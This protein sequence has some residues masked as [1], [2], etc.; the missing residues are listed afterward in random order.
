M[1]NKIDCPCCG[2]I[3]QLITEYNDV[4]VGSVNKKVWI[5]FT[6]YQCDYC[7]ESFTTTE[8]DELNLNEINKGIRKFKRLQKIKDLMNK[9]NL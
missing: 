3:A 8:V 4:Y 6:N 2:D 1:I 9:K 5:N 7:D